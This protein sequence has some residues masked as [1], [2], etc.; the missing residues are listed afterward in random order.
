[1]FKRTQLLQF[2]HDVFL[3]V[4]QPL[5]ELNSVSLTFCPCGMR[6]APIALSCLAGLMMAHNN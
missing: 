6:A 2:L 5:R 1:M 4:W 3:N